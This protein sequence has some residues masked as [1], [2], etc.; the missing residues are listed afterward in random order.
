[1]RRARGWEPY[2][3][4][5]AAFLAIVSVGAMLPQ[6]TAA[7][8]LVLQVVVPGS[9]F[10]AYAARGSFPELREMRLS[11]GGLLADVALGLGVAALWVAPYALGVL[12]HP[13][14]ETGFDA[15]AL[16]PG[17]AD[18]GRL[19]RLVGFVGVTPF[20]EELFVRSFLLRG[21]ELVSW[22]GGRLQIDQSRDFRDLPM[23]R[24]TAWSFWISV[25][26]FGMSHQPWEWPVA[27]ATGAIYTLWL[28]RRGHIGACVLAHAVTNA[29]I[30][31]LVMGPWG[32]GLEYFL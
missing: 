19:L 30:Y 23:A 16:G 31:A 17:W 2:L 6:R 21:A 24:Y 18:A 29:A 3:V 5:Y 25:V 22:R 20:V 27:F 14:P 9:L 7:F 32:R 13:G 4:P 11:P 10:V 8:V 12:G 28:Y 1:M 26:Y 15:D